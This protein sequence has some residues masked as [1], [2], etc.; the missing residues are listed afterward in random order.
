MR[1]AA[2]T[3]A[4]TV[5]TVVLAA[6][7][8]TVD[9]AVVTHSGLVQVDVPGS[10]A[11]QQ[12][13][14]DGKRVCAVTEA[15]NVICGASGPTGAVSSWAPAFEK[16][17]TWV[18]V[19]GDSMWLLDGSSQLQYSP[20]NDTSAWRSN[21]YVMTG[22]A[23]VSDGRCTCN[24]FLSTDVVCA[25]ANG[26]NNLQWFTNGISRPTRAIDI[27]QSLLVG[28]D[29]NGTSY[30]YTCEDFLVEV[31]WL[32]SSTGPYRS[33][34]TDGKYTCATKE[35]TESVF[36]FHNDTGDWQPINA[37][38][39]QIS[40]RDGR[41]YGVARNGTLWTTQ[42]RVD[43]EGSVDLASLLKAESDVEGALN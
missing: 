18:A 23:V 26:R 29:V 4:A 32:K 11:A 15:P 37:K 9:A 24:L 33:I 8:T 7:A 38:F 5:A 34:S 30:A 28:I 10:A 1:T 16:R 2:A 3:K 43:T 20:T 27:G 25:P 31:S 21:R 12:V 19:A 36:C 14:F 42:L 17:A 35:L 41:L 13:S 6:A 39:S 22:K 40:I